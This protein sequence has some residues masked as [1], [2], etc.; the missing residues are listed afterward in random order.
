MLLEMRAPPS[1]HPCRKQRASWV[2]PERTGNRNKMVCLPFIVYTYFFTSVLLWWMLMFFVWAYLMQKMN[3]WLQN[4]TTTMNTVLAKVPLY[5]WSM[6]RFCIFS[7]L[8]W[9]FCLALC[10]IYFIFIYF[11][12][13]GAGSYIVTLHCYL[14]V[15]KHRQSSDRR[16]L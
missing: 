16:S 4:K 11:L 6:F 14:S 12:T 9:I 5:R 3:D 8:R 15:Y 13:Q 2:A 7:F 1:L 10:D